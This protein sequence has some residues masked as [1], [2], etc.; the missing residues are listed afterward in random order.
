MCQ[1]IIIRCYT[2]QGY[3]VGKENDFGSFCSL[4]LAEQYEPKL[5]PDFSIKSLQILEISP[6]FHFAHFTHT[7]T[8]YY[9]MSLIGILVF[10]LL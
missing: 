9:Q 2:V 8:M 10:H 7:Y 4:N 3:Y 5:F 1:F 6:N